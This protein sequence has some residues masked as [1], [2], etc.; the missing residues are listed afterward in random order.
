VAGQ[1]V[2]R[3]VW[4]SIMP[5]GIDVESIMPK[6]IDVENKILK[7]VC[8]VGLVGIDQKFYFRCNYNPRAFEFTVLIEY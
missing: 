1:S 3:I 7:I 4:P 2:G 5:K 6:D 8:A